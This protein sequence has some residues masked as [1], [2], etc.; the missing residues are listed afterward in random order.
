MLQDTLRAATGQKEKLDTQLE[1]KL[2]YLSDNYRTTYENERGN[3]TEFTDIDNKRLQINLNKKSIEELGPVNIGAIEEF[4]TVD[5][6]YQFL[7]EQQEDLMDARET[8]L[9]VISEMDDTVAERFETAYHEVNHHFGEVFKEM[10]GGG[11]AE[12]RLTEEDDFLNSGIEIYAQPPGKKLSS[13]S[14]LS[15]GKER[16]RPSAFIQHA[17]SAGQPI[18]HSG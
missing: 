13:L 4:K 17:E 15:G 3:Y 8:L 11:L 6:R 14:L 18:H 12:L 16:S 1:Q 10:F 2:Q 5:E 9:E 7:K